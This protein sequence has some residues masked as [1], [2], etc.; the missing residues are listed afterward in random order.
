MRLTSP[1]R[2][3][4]RALAPLQREGTRLAR[5]PITGEQAT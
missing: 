5:K 3:R 1:V 2:A 4:K